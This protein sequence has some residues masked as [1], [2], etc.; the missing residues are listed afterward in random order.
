MGHLILNLRVPHRG[1]LQR[2]DQAD[3]WQGAAQ[4]AVPVDKNRRLS[5]SR[6]IRTSLAFYRR[7]ESDVLGL[8][9]SQV[10]ASASGS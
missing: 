4:E 6:I 7:A 10:G 1:A 9:A 5:Q 3:R 8:H 2:H